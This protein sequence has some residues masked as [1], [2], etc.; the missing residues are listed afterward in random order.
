MKKAATTIIANAMR[1]SV[2]SHLHPT[3][4][5]GGLTTGRAAIKYLNEY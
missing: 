2:I 1:L 3:S 4:S 5:S